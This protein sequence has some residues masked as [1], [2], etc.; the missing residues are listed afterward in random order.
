MPVRQGVALPASKSVT[1]IATARPDAVEVFQRHGLAFCTCRG[2]RSLA[3][4]CRGCGLDAAAVLAEIDAAENREPAADRDWER[5]TTEELV[6]HVVAAHHETLDWEL[7]RIL[8]LAAKAARIH[9]EHDPRFRE[10]HGV[11]AEITAELVPHM[12]EQERRLFPAIVANRRGPPIRLRD[13]GFDRLA[14]LLDRVGAL[15]EGFTLPPEPCPTQRALWHALQRFEA[16]QRE[17]L[18]LER[19]VL[20]PRVRGR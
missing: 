14:G 7:V 2:H 13:D 9:G 19:D 17:H 4:A 1:E 12:D 15:T 11:L 10:L 8:A 16:G 18:R 20:Y 6:A 3:A 5:A